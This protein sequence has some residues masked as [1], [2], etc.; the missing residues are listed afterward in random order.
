MILLELGVSKF[1]RL[2]CG[3]DRPQRSAKKN[4]NEGRGL[5]DLTSIFSGDRGRPQD[6]PLQRPF[7]GGERRAGSKVKLLHF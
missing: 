2:H 1:A 4:R 7:K 6:L 3:V 5:Q